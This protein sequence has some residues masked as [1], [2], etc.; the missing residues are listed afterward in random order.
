MAWARGALAR[1]AWAAGA[2]RVTPFLLHTRFARLKWCISRRGR[3]VTSA[4]RLKIPA[5]RSTRPTRRLPQRSCRF[6]ASSPSARRGR[7]TAR[8]RA[9]GK[10]SCG[11]SRRATWAGGGAAAE[12][13]RAVVRELR[14]GPRL[15]V[16]RVG[17][18]ELGVAEAEGVDPPHRLREQ[19]PRAAA[20]PPEEGV[21]QGERA[22]GRHRRPIPRRPVA[23]T[24]P[25][26][27]LRRRRPSRRSFFA[28]RSGY[29][30]FID[31]YISVAD[32]LPW[33]TTLGL[34][35]MPPSHIQAAAAAGSRP[36]AA[37]GRA[38]TPPSRRRSACRSTRARTACGCQRARAAAALEVDVVPM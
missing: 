1:A 19:V 31:L 7:A 23:R 4:K 29:V 11:R 37:T 38:P 32:P 17:V 25:R 16:G 24:T 2:H 9:V 30:C 15:E 22:A 20:A 3:G 10:I 18:D 14:L 21:L 36:S 27:R 5:P 13:E 35:V 12:G 6:L 8:R 26:P 33:I 34:D 28:V